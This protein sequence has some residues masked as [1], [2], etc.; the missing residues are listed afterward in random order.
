MLKLRKTLESLGYKVDIYNNTQEVKEALL[1]KIAIDETVGFGGSVTVEEVGIY[2]ALESRG[3]E[4]YWHWK[5]EDR[6]EAL[7]KAMT[8]DVY[9][10]S[11]NALTEDGKLVNMDGVGNRVASMIYGHKTVYIVVGQNKICKDYNGARERIKSF[12]GPRNAMRLKLNTPCVQA[13]RCNDCNSPQRICN[14][15]SIIHRKPS[16]TSINI[17]LVKESLGY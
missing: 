6:E 15:E 1:D 8:S 4:V 2:E 11:T 5:A 10:S 17:L 3:N 7:A 13:G 12:A 9:I 14:I 16:G